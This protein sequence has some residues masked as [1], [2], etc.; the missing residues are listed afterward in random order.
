MDL[1]GAA[2]GAVWIGVCLL[3]PL[4]QRRWRIRDFC[5]LWG[6]DPDT[7]RFNKIRFRVGRN[8]RSWVRNCVSIGLSSC[9]LE[10]LESTGIYFIYAALYQL[11]KHFPDRTF[12]PVLAERFNEAIEVMYDD[13][14]DFVQ[15]HYCCSP[16]EDT[17]FWRAN[18]HDLRISDS[19]RHKLESYKAGLPVNM[20]ITDVDGYYT[21][22][23]AELQNFWT[24]GSFYCILAGLGSHPDRILPRSG[25]PSAR[26]RPRRGC[27]PTSS[28]SRPSWRARCRR[29]TIS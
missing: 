12:D 25:M 2:P 13:S 26:S 24:N 1:E 20:P 10:P 23:E 22:F 11:A 29:T 14:R 16:R 17:P 6:L 5:R 18:R 19:L 3:Q 21:N 4:R 15:M 27:L 28:A 8:R 7:T 9:F